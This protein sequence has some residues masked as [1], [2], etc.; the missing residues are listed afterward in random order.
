MKTW[1]DIKEGDIIYYWDHGKLHAQK[2]HSVEID[3]EVRK[4][5]YFDSV[6]IKIEMRHTIK[7]GY[8]TRI[9]WTGSWMDNDQTAI[10]RGIRRFTCIEAAQEYMESRKNQLNTKRQKLINKLNKVN[11]QLENYTIGLKT[12]D[13][14][15]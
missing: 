10:V 1:K 7:A 6:N 11:K 3:K 2:V 8:G 5:L 15:T 14:F 13:N 4:Y 12:I 9:M